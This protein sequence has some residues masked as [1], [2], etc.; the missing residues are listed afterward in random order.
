[1]NN[2]VTRRL[3]RGLA[4]LV[5]AV[6]GLVMVGA[7]PAHA[8]GNGEWSVSPTGA[9]GV[10]PR[11][12][13][14]YQLRPGQTLRDLVSVSNLTDH[15]MTFAIYP[16]D[17][18]NTPLDGSFALRLQKDQMT[19]AGS[20]VK[21]GYQTLDVPAKSRADLPF[22][23]DIPADAPPGDH[24]AGIIAEDTTPLDPLTQGKGVNVQR[25]VGTRIYV[26]VAGPLQP[27][28]QVTQIGV[29]KT[30][31][32]LP[33]FTGR[34]HA[35]VAYQVTNTGNVRLQGQS[36]LRIKNFYGRILKTYAT[37]DL[38]ELL[39]KGSVIVT[40]ELDSMPIVDRLTAEVTLTAPGVKTVRSKAFWDIP[41][42]EVLIVL[43]LIALE[44]GRRR[45]KRRRDQ[46]R[47]EP[48]AGPGSAAQAKEPALV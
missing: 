9:D 31:A 17:A 39:P 16:S 33:P 18:Y 38:P 14:E 46:R 35:V 32:L 43:A 44:Y 47:N 37:V 3:V 22:E 29:K 34:G 4:A 40:A 15:A 25:R 20:W 24:A 21:L 7:A 6:G 1:M 11:D 19:D 48:P 8:S 36:T 27:S 5:V 12:W 13:F 45:Y 28:L 2:Q 30:Q 42:L 23:I 10:I 26:R 41:W